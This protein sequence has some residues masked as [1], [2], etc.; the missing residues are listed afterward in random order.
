MSITYRVFQ[1]I[2]FLNTIHNFSHEVYHFIFFFRL[3]HTITISVTPGYGFE[4]APAGLDISPGDVI[5]HQ[6]LPTPLI[7]NSNTDVPTGSTFNNY[8]CNGLVGPVSFTALQ[9][10][11][12]SEFH[13]L[14][15]IYA[16][17]SQALF[18]L[19]FT[20]PGSVTFQVLFCIDLASF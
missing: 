14:K 3:K 11:I 12:S 17:P 20:N 2:F 16:Q 19:Q 8:Y 15:G 5:A 18:P 9:C 4:P 7:A 1:G 6:G 13:Q 10:S